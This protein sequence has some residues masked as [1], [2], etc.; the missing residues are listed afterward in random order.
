[1]HFIK[2]CDLLIYNVRFNG[3]RRKAD[4]WLQTKAHS[5]KMDIMFGNTCNQY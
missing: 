2:R 4:Y 3:S 1:M 5:V